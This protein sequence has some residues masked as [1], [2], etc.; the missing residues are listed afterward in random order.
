M[1]ELKLISELIGAT[2]Y[3]FFEVEESDRKVLIPCQGI[4]DL[5]AQTLA[6]RIGRFLVADTEAK[7]P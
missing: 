5:E 6:D 7:R 1:Y 2:E 4:D 3:W